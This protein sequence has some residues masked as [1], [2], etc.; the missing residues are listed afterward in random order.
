MSGATDPLS[1]LSAS[2]ADGEA[3]DWDEVRAL[4]GDEDIRH[5]LEHLRIV[6]G[7]AEVH[8]SQIAET[9]AASLTPAPDPGLTATSGAEPQRW[10]HLLLIRKIGEGAFGEVFEALDT[11]LDHPR[12]LKLLKPEVANRTSAPQILHEARKLVRVRHPNVVMVHGAD[13]HQG[14]VGFWMDLIEGQTLEQRVHQGRLSAGE[15]IY[16][17]QELCRALAAVHLANLLHRDIKAQNVMRASDGGRII[18]MDF[19]AG[20]FRDVPTAGR[21]QGTPLYLAPELITGGAATVQSDI[22]ALGVLLYYLVTGRF[23]VEGTSLADLVIAHAQGSRRHLRD[24]RPDLPDSFVTVVERAIDPLPALRFQSAG[25]LHAA[26]EEPEISRPKRLDSVP[27]LAPVPEPSPLH[28]LG[29]VVL[30]IVVVLALIEVIGFIACRIFDVA[31][32]VPPAFRVG[33]GE[34]F[35]VG[36]DCLLPFAIYWVIGTVLFAVLAGVRFLLQPAMKRLTGSAGGH[37]EPFAATTLAT[38]IPVVGAICWATITWV[39]LSVFTTLDALAYSVPGRATDIAILGPALKATHIS[40]GNLS[41]WL[42]FLLVLAVWRLWPA[43][44]QRSDNRSV[45]R[46]MKWAT[47]AVAFVVMATASAPR[48]VVWDKFE[49]VLYKNQPSFVIGTYSDE[50]LLCPAGTI[51]AARHRVRRNDP[52]LVPTNETRALVDR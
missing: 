39:H 24:A 31:L 9:L 16:V 45:T 51:G 38:I 12:A 34:Y 3:I 15:A 13:R 29:Q 7:V 37:L 46:G 8:R 36:R 17:G 14:R 26:L 21:P 18:L 10:G 19:G 5:L 52:E 25:E 49:V 35:R 6:A 41:A 30:G 40:H 1:K 27:L 47:I 2:I 32:R 23:P 20:E 50:L 33:P 44:E 11:W 48:R 42:S 4:A 43:L 28:R 22:Y